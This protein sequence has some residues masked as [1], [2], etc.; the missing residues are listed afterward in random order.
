VGRGSGARSEQHDQGAQ[1]GD[2]RSVLDVRRRPKG[3]AVTL[4]VNW[5]AKP[6]S[7][8]FLGWLFFKH[9]FGRWDRARRRGRSVRA[10]N[11]A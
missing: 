9:L 4:F 3:I 8:A 5:L 2:P 10:E 7:M 6:F 11:G 1:D